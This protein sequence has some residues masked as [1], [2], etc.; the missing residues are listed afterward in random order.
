MLEM[1]DNSLEPQEDFTGLY[2]VDSTAADI[3]VKVLKDTLLPFSLSIDRCRGYDRASSMS[4][5]HRG[6]AVKIASEEPCAL[7]AM[8]MHLT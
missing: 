4:G 7:T 6:P 2:K 1:V 3:I 8:A 5:R